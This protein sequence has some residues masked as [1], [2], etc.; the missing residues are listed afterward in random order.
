MRI[1][2][3]SALPLTEHFDNDSYDATW[4][5]QPSGDYLLPWSYDDEFDA[6]FTFNSIFV[7]D[8]SNRK[9]EILSPVLNLSSLSNPFVSFDV[10]FNYTSF[11]ANGADTTFTDTLEVLVSTNCGETYQSVYKKAGAALAT[12]A[13]PIVNPGDL[14]AYFISPADS[15]WRRET[16]DLTPYATS[17][18][19]V[20]K[21]SYISGLG[22]AIF[23]D[24][25]AFVNEQTD[26]KEIP[27]AQVNIY[28]NPAK[29]QCKLECGNDIIQ[30]VTVHD[31]AGKQ[32]YSQ[33]G[34]GGK[35]MMLSTTTLPNGVY[36]LHITTA[37]GKANKKI[38][39][40]H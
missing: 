37:N 13:S 24:N 21:F 38:V 39:V 29:D 28:P 7:F 23:L 1:T 35:G 31:I 26:I 12:F 19:A 6:L 2:A 5:S 9:E 22:G 8:N 15:N 27:A 4:L 18:N 25:I 30:M 10:A 36:L 20:V 17:Q 40:Q 32:I 14:N 33:Q 3:P 34:D 11:M 16:I